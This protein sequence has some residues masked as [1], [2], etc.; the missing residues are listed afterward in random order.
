M[1]APSH[2]TPRAAG[3]TVSERRGVPDGTPAANDP[4]HG[5]LAAHEEPGLSVWVVG[6]LGGE[7]PPANGGTRLWHY[8]SRGHGLREAHMLAS[9]M[10]AKHALYGTGF[11]GGKIVAHAEEP[12]D[13]VKP[14]LLEVLAQLLDEL[15]GRMMTGCDLN[16]TGADMAALARRSPYVLAAV[17]SPVDASAATAHGVVGSFLSAARDLGHRRGAVLR[18]VLVHGVGAVGRTVAERLAANGFEVL[19]IDRD[20]DRASVPGC[21]PL[22]PSEAWWTVPQDATVLCSAS[23]LVD[24]AIAGELTTQLLVSATN[25]PFRDRVAREALAARGALVLPDHLSNV[26]AVLVDSIEHHCPDAWHRA[27]A[28]DVYRFVESVVAA[29]TGAFL[30]LRDAGVDETAALAWLGRRQDRPAGLLFADRFR[31]D[32]ETGQEVSAA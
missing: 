5:V 17:D 13:A 14:R 21:R 9:R 31:R 15:G 6:E 12:L 1:S 30:H 18:R 25:G 11:R 7:G 24:A 3:T 29:Q 28:D 19:T 8:P 4:G 26:G 32:H 20:L 2:E 16:V 10:S 27:E 23:G 22:S